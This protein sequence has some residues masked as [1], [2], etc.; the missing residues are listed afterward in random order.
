MFHSRLH[1]FLDLVTCVFF[2]VLASLLIVLAA[3]IQ[4]HDGNYPAFYLGFG[5]WLECIYLAVHFGLKATLVR[6]AKLAE[7]ISAVLGLLLMIPIGLI[8]TILAVL[9]EQS[10]RLPLPAEERITVWVYATIVMFL[11]VVPSVL[12]CRHIV[13]SF[14]RQRTEQAL[15][16]HSP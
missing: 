5:V 15:G 1:S 7:K 4:I 14:L 3:Q 6:R 12:I 10:I 9:L 11:L 2:L 13:L 8:I 16:A